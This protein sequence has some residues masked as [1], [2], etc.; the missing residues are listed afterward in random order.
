[1][2]GNNA[3]FCRKIWREGLCY[4]NTERVTEFLRKDKLV[5]H[6]LAPGLNLTPRSCEAHKML[7]SPD[8][9]CIWVENSRRL[10]KQSNLSHPSLALNHQPHSNSELTSSRSF[11]FDFLL[12]QG[13]FYGAIHTA[14]AILFVFTGKFG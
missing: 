10:T 11:Q 5:K 12:A 8:Y 7:C 6:L 3:F 1:M 9:W 4:L 2:T 13:Y 14:A